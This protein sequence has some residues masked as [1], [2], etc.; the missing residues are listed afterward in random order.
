MVL[1]FTAASHDIASGRI[2]DT[3]TGTAG[4]IHSLKN[5]DVISLHLAIPY[6]EACCCKRSKSA[7]YD[8]SAL[9]VYA[10]GLLRSGK[11]FV[12]TIGIIDSFTVLV[13][14]AKLGIAV[15]L[16][17]SG[18]RCSSLLFGSACLAAL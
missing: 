2:K 15:F 10:I 4:N 11:S 8:V 14:S 18:N 5:M 1:H 6:K 3:I 13:I 7:S 17:G 12:V 16:F 9:F